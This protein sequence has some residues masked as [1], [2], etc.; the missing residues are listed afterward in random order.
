MR[1]RTSPP[2]DAGG[3]AMSYRYTMMRGASY[4]ALLL[5]LAVYAAL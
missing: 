5:A 3:T 1:T 4:L 2:P